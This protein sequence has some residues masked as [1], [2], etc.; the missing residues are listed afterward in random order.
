MAI[1]VFRYDD[2]NAPAAPATSVE[3]IQLLITL[4]TT[5]YTGKPG[6]GWTV[7]YDDVPNMNPVILQHPDGDMFVLQPLTADSFEFGMC[8]SAD[9][10]GV[11][12]NYRSGSYAQ[13]TGYRQRMDNAGTQNWERWVA[14]YD[15]VSH[16]LIFH[17]TRVAYDTWNAYRNSTSFDARIGIYIGSLK[18]PVPGGFAPKVIFAGTP[19]QYNDQNH[20]FQ[21]NTRSYAHRGGHT[22]TVLKPYSDEVLINQEVGF[23]PVAENEGVEAVPSV[24]QTTPHIGVVPALC[25]LNRESTTRSFELLGFIRG[26]K[27]LPSWHSGSRSSADHP[28]RW[29]DPNAASYPSMIAYPLSPGD[30]ILYYTAGDRTEQTGVFGTN[31][32]WW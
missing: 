7:I 18:P 4:L 30:G 14:L 28:A 25:F 26:W 32:D 21:Y 23:V 15:D 20:L 31:L 24:T 11:M 12:D 29:I 19:A 22:G 10:S 9:S 13:G 27:F 6:G 1:N 16:T 5:G 17:A 2:A 8:L 3:C